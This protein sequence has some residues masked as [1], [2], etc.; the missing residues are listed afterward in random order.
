M[1]HSLPQMHELDLSADA[2]IASREQAMTVLHSLYMLPILLLLGYDRSAVQ[3]ASVSPSSAE[4]LTTAL[5]ASICPPV[6]HSA[7]A[8]ATT[9]QEG[10]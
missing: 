8:A 6:V 7:A 3:P 4:H 10:D 5:G 2:R 9:Q 1:L